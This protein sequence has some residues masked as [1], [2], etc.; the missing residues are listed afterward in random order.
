MTTCYNCQKMEATRS[1][2]TLCESCCEN[3]HSWD[4]SDRELLERLGRAEVRAWRKAA[5]EARDFDTTDALDD[6]GLTGMSRW[7]TLEER[8][9]REGV[10]TATVRRAIE[11]G[12]TH[13]RIGRRLEVDSTEP[14]PPTQP[15]GPKAQSKESNW[16]PADGVKVRVT[17]GDGTY[18]E[19]AIYLGGEGYFASSKSRSHLG[20]RMREFCE[21]MNHVDVV[22]D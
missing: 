4:P 21:E 9:I 12:L 5:W 22:V 18:A 1:N 7:E 19:G 11:R 2:D 6:S 13:R 15:P 3:S 16:L 20:R 10:S 17:W 8:A 14:M